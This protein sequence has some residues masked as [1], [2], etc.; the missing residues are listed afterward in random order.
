MADIQQPVANAAQSAANQ[1]ANMQAMKAAG[2]GAKAASNFQE[3][4]DQIISAPVK[5]LS[6]AT[7]IKLDSMM[8]TGIFANAK[9]EDAA[10]KSGDAIN[11]GAASFTANG[12]A[13]ANVAGIVFNKENLLNGISQPVIDGLPIE[14]QQQ[15]ASIRDMVGEGMPVAAM[16][17]GDLG[18]LTPSAGGGM[19]RGEGMGMMA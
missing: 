13:L 4:M 14:A 8:E 3:L 12:G 19:A 9:L 7:G 10:F 16:S 2:S 18:G 15:I 1:A 11:K 17:Y 6:K 5:W